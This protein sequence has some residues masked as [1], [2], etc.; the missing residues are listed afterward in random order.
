MTPGKPKAT[1]LTLR[2]VEGLLLAGGTT[3]RARTVAEAELLLR[4]LSA[5]IPADAGS[6]RVEVAVVFAGGMRRQAELALSHEDAHR[7]MSPWDGVL[8]AWAKE[9]VDRGDRDHALYLVRL[10]ELVRHVAH[11]RAVGEFVDVYENLD[12]DDDEAVTRRARV[13]ASPAPASLVGAKYSEGRS[14]AAI[15]HGVRRDIETAVGNGMLPAGLRCEV[16]IEQFEAG[17]GIEIEVVRAPGI[18]IPDLCQMCVAVAYEVQP[19]PPGGLTCGHTPCIAAHS[20]TADGV[21]LTL[22]AIGDAYNADSSRVEGREYKVSGAFELATFFGGDLCGAQRETLRSSEEAMR[23]RARR[24]AAHAG[25]PP[26][27]PLPPGG[28]KYR[29]AEPPRTAP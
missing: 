6:Q 24:Q 12:D 26:S 13:L 7:E 21:L 10:A 20:V 8:L 17:P 22:L 29:P 3:R 1:A 2:P 15:A 11:Y 25:A 18:W 4:R 19:P 27:P 5:Q 16:R 23:E 9:C 14:L 28:S